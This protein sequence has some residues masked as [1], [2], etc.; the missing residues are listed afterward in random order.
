M[1]SNL[2]DPFGFGT[3]PSAPIDPNEPLSGRVYVGAGLI[4]FPYQNKET[5]KTEIMY[6]VRPG[7]DIN[8]PTIKTG[9]PQPATFKATV[10][11]VFKSGMSEYD[12]NLVFC[13]LEY[14]QEVRNMID[15]ETG[16]SSITSI[17][18]KLHDFAHADEV[19]R[20]LRARNDSWRG[21]VDR[22]GDARHRRRPAGLGL[23]ADLASGA[24][25]RGVSLTPRRSTPT[26]VESVVS[27]WMRVPPVNSML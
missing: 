18:I 2:D 19:V 23:L 8:L 22:P 3:G 9:Q 21:G 15:P 25:R 13:N 6:M 16:V 20:R 11:D 12:S 26:S 27:I 17:Q 1:V 7:Q 5:G 24:C 10:V 14:L 4:S